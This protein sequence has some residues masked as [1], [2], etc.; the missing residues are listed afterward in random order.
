MQAGDQAVEVLRDCTVTEEMLKRGIPLL[1]DVTIQGEGFSIRYDALQKAVGTSGLG[2]F[3]YVP[4]LCHE[5]VGPTREQRT[6]LELLGLILGLVQGRE[7]ESGRLFHGSGCQESR[8]KLHPDSR[9]IR[10]LLEQIRALPTADRPRL[11]LNSHCQVCEFREQC[12]AEAKSRNDLS[13]VRG[14]S[15]NEV[16]K[17]GQR[18]NHP[19]Q[20]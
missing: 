13:L 17:W 3:H 7:P 10:R 18:G 8:L 5:S 20:W 2:S 4:V 12:L 16:I 11:I 15:E 6:L 9:R 1:L 14:M 19:E